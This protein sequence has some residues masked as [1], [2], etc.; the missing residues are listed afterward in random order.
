MSVAK[1][2]S[3]RERIVHYKYAAMSLRTSID[4]DKRD[5]GYFYLLNSHF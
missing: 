5:I 4:L 3:L 2:R 1:E